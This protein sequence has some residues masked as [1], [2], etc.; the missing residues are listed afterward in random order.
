MRQ[1]GSAGLGEDRVP[2][3]MI[4]VVMS[5][6]HEADRQ[7]RDL[8]NFRQQLFCWGNVDKCIYN[9]N[10]LAAHDKASI[11]AC[12]AA[13]RTDGRIDSHANLLYGE[14]RSLGGKCT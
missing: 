13:V 2:A 1:N 9:K 11:A 3:R 12:R 4:Q 7:V 14:I 5:V 8:A 6:D 10:F